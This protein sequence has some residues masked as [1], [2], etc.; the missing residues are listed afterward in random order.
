MELMRG[1]KAPEELSDEEADLMKLA[2]EI[3]QFACKQKH[4]NPMWRVRTVSIA[5]GRIMGATANNRAALMR[6]MNQELELIRD[7]ALLYMKQ[8]EDGVVPSP[9]VP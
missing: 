4:K 2:N 3:I 5:L 1:G 9:P 6:G 7:G 8:R